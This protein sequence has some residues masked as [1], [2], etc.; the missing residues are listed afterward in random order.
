MN[1]PDQIVREARF[2]RILVQWAGTVDAPF[3]LVEKLLEIGLGDSV[4]ED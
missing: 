3:E 2:V 4:A 1:L